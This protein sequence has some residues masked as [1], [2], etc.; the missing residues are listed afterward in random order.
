V[1]G[2][3]QRLQPVLVER[4]LSRPLCASAAAAAAARLPLLLRP[5]RKMAPVSPPGESGNVSIDAIVVV[6]NDDVI[7]QR[8]LTNRIKT[9]TARMKAQNVQMPSRPTCAASCWSA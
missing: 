6:V 1:H 7:T 5:P 4:S 9:V 2:R 8:E 3:A